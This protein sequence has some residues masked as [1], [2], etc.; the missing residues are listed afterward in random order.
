MSTQSHPLFTMFP[1][2]GEQEISIGRV[3]TPYQTYDG[4]GLFIGGTADLT[5]ITQVLQKEN[6][7]PMQ[8]VNGRAVMGIWVVDFTEASLGP[9]QELQFSILVAHQPTAPIEDHPLTLLKALFSNVDAR[10]FCAG[11]WNDTETAVAYNRE[12]LGLNAQLTKGHIERKNGQ[13][14]FHF[15]D[16]NGHLLFEGQVAEAQQAS[17][18]VGFALMRLLGMRQT[19]RAFRQPYLEA[20]VVNPIGD[21][22]PF[23]GDAQSYLASDAP[24]VQFYNPATDHITF[25]TLDATRFDF[26]PQFVEHFE[27]FRFVYLQPAKSL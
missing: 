22:L 24:V 26:N 2:N 20:K 4:H 10:M 3:P 5:R 23:N 18:R 8:T 16:E 27:P 19:I 12:L 7:Y 25:N 15:S 11:L 9:H 1:L 14:E 21:T 6:V 13:K 17:P